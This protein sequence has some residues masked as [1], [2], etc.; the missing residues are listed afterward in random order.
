MK[1]LRIIARLLLSL[2]RP[3]S[4]PDPRV[5]FRLES[6]DFKAF[7]SLDE[8]NAEFRN[9]CDAKGPSFHLDQ[10]HADGHFRV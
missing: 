1:I 4:E 7:G 10:S 6:P 5:E 2:R 9:L 8:Y 3:Q